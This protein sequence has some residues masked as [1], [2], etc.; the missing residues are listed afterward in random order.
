[1]FFAVLKLLVMK[2][3]SEIKTTASP[4]YHH[5]CWRF[6]HPQKDFSKNQTTEHI[7]HMCK[8]VQQGKFF[9]NETSKHEQKNTRAGSLETTLLKRIMLLPTAIKNIKSSGGHGHWE[10]HGGYGYPHTYLQYKPDFRQEDPAQGSKTCACGAAWCCVKRST[11]HLPCV[12]MLRLRLTNCLCF[13]QVTPGSA[14]Q[15][16]PSPGLWT[17]F[18]WAAAQLNKPEQTF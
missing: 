2:W 11:W 1:M 5:H 14:T 17:V 4:V 13:F 6:L 9:H 7:P 16:A 8:Q 3:G 12:A 18:S 15:E 10:R